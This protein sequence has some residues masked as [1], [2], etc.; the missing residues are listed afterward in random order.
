MTSWVAGRKGV[1][2]TA[3]SLVA[4]GEDIVGQLED[5]IAE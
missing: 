4:M 5:H 1:E 2:E 3:Q